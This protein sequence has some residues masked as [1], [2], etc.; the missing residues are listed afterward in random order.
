[1]WD[2]A[3]WRVGVTAVPD[4]MAQLNAQQATISTLSALV[5]AGL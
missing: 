2:G 5:Y 4:V 1:V 3:A